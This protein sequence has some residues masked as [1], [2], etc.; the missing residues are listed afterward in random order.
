VRKQRTG[1]APQHA[2]IDRVIEERLEPRPEPIDV[3]EHDRLG[4]IA[5]VQPGELLERLLE[6]AEPAGRD[7]ERV[8]ELEQHRLAL[9]HRVDDMEL[10]QS[11][12]RDLALDQRARMT[13]IARPPAASTASA[14]TPIRP[15]WAP[16]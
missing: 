13:P 10:G 6:R 7:D 4:V 16:P 2:H 1:L 3:E 8:G 9:M 12:V 14:I 5:E 11:A 15:R